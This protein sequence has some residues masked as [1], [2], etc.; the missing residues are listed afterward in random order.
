[1]ARSR[2]KTGLILTGGGAR[3]AYQIGVLKAVS[4]ILGTGRHNPF[5]ILCGTSAGAINAAVLATDAG[6]FRRG[7]RRLMTVWKNFHVHH[8]YRADAYGAL[9]NSARWL[10]RPTPGKS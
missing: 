5:P 2:E 7:V 6:N 1:M 4:E 3:A 9:S 8:V 10:A